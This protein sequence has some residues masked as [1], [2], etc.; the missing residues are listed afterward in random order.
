MSLLEDTPSPRS[1]SNSNQNRTISNDNNNQSDEYDGC[2]VL[3]ENNE[4]P[5]GYNDNEWVELDDVAEKPNIV[6]NDKLFEPKD[7]YIYDDK[8]DPNNKQTTHRRFV[9]QHSENNEQKKKQS[10]ETLTPSNGN[11]NGNNT[12]SNAE[13]KKAQ[14]ATESNSHSRSE[15]HLYPRLPLTPKRVRGGQLTAKKI[16]PTVHRVLLY[17]SQSPRLTRKHHSTNS[18][19]QNVKAP[20][21][22]GQSGGQDVGDH[23]SNNYL[24]DTPETKEFRDVDFD[25]D[26]DLDNSKL[27]HQTF[28]LYP[29]Y[30]LLL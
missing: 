29:N 12:S 19:N 3:S 2:Y 6:C 10:V 27:A 21:P 16:L 26:D 15:Q 14:K 22:K 7:D 30:F 9:Q 23:L 24:E 1:Q 5:F 25:N 20:N 18:R 13:T 4:M 28:N 8:F 17:N 11:N